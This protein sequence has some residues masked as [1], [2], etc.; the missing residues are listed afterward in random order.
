MSRILKFLVPVVASFALLSCG[1]D[2][3]YSSVKDNIVGHYI[4]T[5]EIGWTGV[6]VDLN[7]DGH[8]SESMFDECCGTPGFIA[9]S[10]SADISEVDS[11][12]HKFCISV[13]FPDY[14][15]LEV[16]G[17]LI[18]LGFIYRTIKLDAYWLDSEDPFPSHYDRYYK[19]DSEYSDKLHT[20]KMAYVSPMTKP[21]EFVF[22][23]DCELYGN[24]Y[25][26]LYDGTMKYHFKR[27]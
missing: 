21:G 23:V 3:M 22:N 8:D 14:Q 17:S 11:K 16:D 5:E 18:P 4:T 7:D 9:S 2:D 15:I 26:T 1:K 25:G 27:K 12:E 24:V 13:T 20:C 19:R 10:I 6:L